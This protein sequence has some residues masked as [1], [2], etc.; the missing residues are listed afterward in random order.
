MHDL[1]QLQVRDLRLQLGTHRNDLRPDPG[2]VLAAVGIGDHAVGG[3]HLGDDP[4]DLAAGEGTQ[5][6]GD[7]FALA[8]WLGL[9]GFI[10]AIVW[11]YSWM[12][13]RSAAR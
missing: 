7:D 4:R 10:G 5:G 13:R 6:R 8:P 12:L 2:R 3:E 1:L 9:F 11:L